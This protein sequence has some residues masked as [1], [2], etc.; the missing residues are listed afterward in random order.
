MSSANDLPPCSWQC[1]NPS[2]P[3]LTIEG[4]EHCP[5]CYS[6]YC[7][8]EVPCGSNK[9]RNMV[10]NYQ[11]SDGTWSTEAYCP[12]CKPH[13]KERQFDQVMLQR[14]KERQ[15]CDY[16]GCTATV[17]KT[18]GEKGWCR[19]CRQYHWTFESDNAVYR[20]GR[21]Q[22]PSENTRFTTFVNN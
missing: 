11:R 17:Y 15:Q 18:I 12:N 21:P 20:R 3:E 9:C 6:L 19:T 2:D 16:P 5:N 8:E 13:N 7:V 4:E 10:S 14:N 1:G 22:S